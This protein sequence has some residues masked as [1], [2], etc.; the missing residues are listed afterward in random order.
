MN[1]K[2]K[3]MLF[4]SNDICAIYEDIL[5]SYSKCIDIYN[6]ICSFVNDNDLS[7]KS[8]VLVTSNS[9][10]D[11]LALCS[12]LDNN[13]AVALVNECDHDIK[14]KLEISCCE[15]IVCFNHNSFSF[16][17]NNIRNSSS[18]IETLLNEHKSGLII[19]SSG[20]TGKPKAVLHDW[21][22]FSSKYTDINFNRRTMLIFLG[23]DH[24]G[25][26]NT[27]F[28]SLFSGGIS[29]F[30]KTTDVKYVCKVIEKYKVNVL[31]TTPSYLNVLFICNAFENYDFT[32][33]KLISYGT[34]RMNP[35]ILRS[36][37]AK[38]PNVSF[39]QTYGLSE[40]GIMVTHS[41]KNDSIYM[42]LGG[43]GFN[44]KIVNGVLYIKSK[45]SMV[46]Y[47]NEPSPFVDGWYNTHDI[48]KEKEDG[49]LEIL[50]RESD[51]V[52][53]HGNK[54]SLV[55]LEEII[56]SSFSDIQD[57]VLLKASHAFLGDY[58]FAKMVLR[59]G[60]SQE[61]FEKEFYKRIKEL[62]PQ[63]FIPVKIQFSPSTLTNLRWKKDR[64]N[65]DI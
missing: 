57:C 16:E 3:L 63:S 25:G 61:D 14:S 2:S 58:L 4:P 46:C 54:Q 22:R 36:I 50:G 51:I 15:Y 13:C 21:E 43:N 48:V 11:G 18:E 29:V 65:V 6:S 37:S 32:S 28:S 40:L 64:S 12:L 9:L 42:K 47:L 5:Y 33:V 10:I 23:L 62:I 49:F 41:E 30:I 44:Y 55:Q 53:I 24:I 1:I 34:E 31:P 59:T 60:T 39:L 20:T 52:N 7:N 8:V 27:L 26:L 17:K 56:C 35:D 38:L 19:F 45:Y